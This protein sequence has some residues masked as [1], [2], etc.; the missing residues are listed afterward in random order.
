[1]ISIFRFVKSY[2]FNAIRRKLVAIYLLNITDIVFTLLLFKTIL[3]S[4]VNPI[5]AKVI[6]NQTGSVLLKI[7]LP[8][9]L[10]VYILMRMQKA[11]IKQLKQANVVIT[12]CLALYC[13]ILI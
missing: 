9:L 1:M 5:M 8:L 6:S 12:G 3:F 10:I 13:A 7:T 4:E 11:D 2:D